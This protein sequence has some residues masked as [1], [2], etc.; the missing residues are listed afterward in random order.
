MKDQADQFIQLQADLE[1]KYQDRLIVSLDAAMTSL[2][3]SMKVNHKVSGLEY[4]QKQRIIEDLIAQWTDAAEVSEQIMKGQIASGFKASSDVTN[5]IDRYI[6]T[7][8]ATKSQQIISTTEKQMADLVQG[9]LKRGESMDTVY[10]NL[11]QKIPDIAAGRAK[12]ITRTEIH[13]ASQFASQKIAEQAQIT[14]TKDWV[15]VKDDFTRGAPT[16]PSD[17]FNHWVM[18]GVKVNL[19]QPFK[20]PTRWG[21]FEEIFFPGDPRG[22]AGNIINCRC[23]QV[24]RRLS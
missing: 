1:G 8:G 5:L 4:N 13:T 9:G 16:H 14:L 23:V 19:D 24:Y 15:S 22:S 18:D 17:Q 11:V 10:A 7:F 3:D 21:G 12:I 6:T 2:L 20:V